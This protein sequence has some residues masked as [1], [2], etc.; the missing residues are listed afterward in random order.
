M[1]TDADKGKRATMFHKMEDLME[2]EGGFVFI[3][4]EPN[5]AI[6]DSDLIPVILADGHPDP[7]RFA[8]T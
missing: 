1:L 6:H 2:D 3:C 4:F 7:T 8:A 5:V